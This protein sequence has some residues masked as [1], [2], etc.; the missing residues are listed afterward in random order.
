[1]RKGNESYRPTVLLM[2]SRHGP[3]LAQTTALAIIAFRLRVNA[4]GIVDPEG[5]LES[6]R[7]LRIPEDTIPSVIDIVDPSGL[8]RPDGLPLVVGHIQRRQ[9]DQLR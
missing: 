5:K 4:E 2:G 1:M 9:C 8:C 3:S 6:D 7:G